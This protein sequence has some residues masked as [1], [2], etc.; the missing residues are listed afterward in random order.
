MTFNLRTRAARNIATAAIISATSGGSCHYE[1]GRF[2]SMANDLPCRGMTL[3]KVAG[4]E[5]L[6]ENLCIAISGDA[7]E[8]VGIEC[9]KLADGKKA[10]TIYVEWGYDGVCEMLRHYK[11]DAEPI[12]LILD[13]EDKPLEIH[14]RA[15]WR[16]GIYDFNSCKNSS[17]KALIAITNAYHT[18]IVVGCDSNAVNP[19]NKGWMYGVVFSITDFYARLT[20]SAS[21]GTF[22]PLERVEKNELPG[23]KHPARTQPIFS[24]R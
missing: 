3:P 11:P 17:G 12:T 14:T 21:L 22:R 4:A 1:A 6:A 19:A 18:P 10:C 24:E 20:G 16:V 7:P 23:P 8:K 15:H 5:P 9:K 13:P 2:N